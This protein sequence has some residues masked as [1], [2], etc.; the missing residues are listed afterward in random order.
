MGGESVER[1]KIVKA[2]VAPVEEL[3]GRKNE[4]RKGGGREGLKRLPRIDVCVMVEVSGRMMV[5]FE[6]VLDKSEL[7][8]LKDLIQYGIL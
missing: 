3:W 2:T 8:T 4:K 1:E 6:G 5:G 7:R